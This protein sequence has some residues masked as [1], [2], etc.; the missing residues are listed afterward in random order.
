AVVTGGSA[1]QNTNNRYAGG[2]LLYGPSNVVYQAT[3]NWAGLLDHAPATNAYDSGDFVWDAANN[4]GAY[5]PNF[6][7]YTLPINHAIAANDLVSDTLGPTPA[8]FKPVQAIADWTAGSYGLNNLVC[9]SN[10]FWKSDTSGNTTTPGAVGANWTEVTTEVSNVNDPAY[11]SDVSVDVNNTT[12]ASNSYWQAADFSDTHLWTDYNSNMTD[13]TDPI[14]WR[15][16]A[17][18]D[19]P[20]SFDSNYWIAIT[21][22]SG[23]GFWAEVATVGPDTGVDGYVGTGDEAPLG[24]T[25]T[26][27]WDQTA[28]P[29]PLD[30]VSGAQYWG[31]VTESYIRSSQALGA[32]DVSSTIGSANWDGAL[33]VN[34]DGTGSF[35]I[36]HGMGGVEITYDTA[37]DTIT[38]LIERVNA[39]DA[40]VT[41]SY[42]AVGDQFIVQSDVTGNLG[43]TLNESGS[44]DSVNAGTGNLL[45]MMGMVSDVTDGAAEVKGVGRAKTATLGENA[46]ITINGG[47]RIFSQSNVFDGDAHGVEGLT[48]NLSKVT[49]G[50]VSFFVERDLDP[51]KAALNKFVEEFN[52]AQQYINSLVSISRDGDNVTAGRFAGNLEISRLGSRL[53]KLVFGGSYPHSASETTSDGTN[54]KVGDFASRDA[55]STNFDSDNDGYRIY[56]DNTGGDLSAHY[57]EWKQA[58]GAPT[59]S[60]ANFTPTFSAFRIND[61]GLDFQS[62]SDEMFIENS[63]LLAQELTDNPNK[64]K[65]LFAEVKPGTAVYDHNTNQSREYGGITYFLNEFI[66]NFLES[67]AGTY[68]THLESLQN[69]NDRLDT[70]IADME[71]YLIQRESTLSQNFIRMEEMQSR[72]NSQ[73]QT[74]QSSFPGN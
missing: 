42:D 46:I 62:G 41:M 33:A 17:N 14:Y 36:G 28:I 55:L 63:A 19:S 51:A 20:A 49:S 61:I 6:T 30:P 74:L 68:K 24:N 67:D 56:I 7:L 8:Y 65:A 13:V 2:E 70:S 43:I 48:I 27:F 39:S 45:E 40:K 12:L 66:D 10:K 26:N 52:D 34:P 31:E 53:R 29:D 21:P 37:T 71:R 59:G 57:Q 3:A 1:A 60:W 25:D 15:A 16:A 23:G 5:T 47:D 35:F 58:P 9:D 54:K 4:S 64:V 11:W 50:E 73:M 18:I 72:M 69:Q 22:G 32:I 38:D 44:W